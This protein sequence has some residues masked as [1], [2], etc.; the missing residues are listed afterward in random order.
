MI[1]PLRLIRCLHRFILR[2]TYITVCILDEVS[3]LKAKMLNGA[4][5]PRILVLAFPTLG[6][7]S[8]LIFNGIA[9]NQE[10]DGIPVSNKKLP[11]RG[12]FT[13]KTS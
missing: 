8:S 3:L 11:F 12:I 5:E 2:T 13:H 1:D 6:Q 9:T 4:L 7:T 10:P